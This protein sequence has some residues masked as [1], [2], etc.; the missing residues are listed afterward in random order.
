VFN[1]L[2]LVFVAAVTSF[3]VGLPQVQATRAAGRSLWVVSYLRA[4]E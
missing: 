4:H 3:L 2:Q 1:V